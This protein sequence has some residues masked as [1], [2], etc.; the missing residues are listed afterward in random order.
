MDRLEK[1]ISQTKELKKRVPRISPSVLALAAQ[2]HKRKDTE[3]KHQRSVSFGMLSVI[4]DDRPEFNFGQDEANFEE[5]KEWIGQ[6]KSF[7][8]ALEPKYLNMM[9]TYHHA[10]S[11]ATHNPPPENNYDVQMPNASRPPSLKMSYPFLDFFKF[12]FVLT[13]IK[14]WPF[15]F[16]GA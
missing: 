9:S 4:E 10:E 14:F 6:F 13:K 8:L 15:I 16:S 2:G 11:S 7:K 3:R 5:V 12:S 1:L